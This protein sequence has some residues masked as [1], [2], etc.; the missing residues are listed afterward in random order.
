MG[1]KTTLLVFLDQFNQSSID[2]LIYAF[3]HT[4]DWQEWLEIKQDVMFRI[5]EI[6]ERHQLE[7]AFPSQSLYFDRGNLS[8]SAEAVDQVFRAGRSLPE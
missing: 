6:L 3:T 4:T 8:E 1:I 2:I 7:F 5:M